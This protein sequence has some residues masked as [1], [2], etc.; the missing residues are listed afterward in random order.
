MLLAKKT[1]YR[2]PDG[3][4]IIRRRHCSRKLYRSW[5]VCGDLLWETFPLAGPAPKTIRIELHDT[6]AKDRVEIINSPQDHVYCDGVEHR[7]FVAGFDWLQPHL[8]KYGIV[9]AE[10]WY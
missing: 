10:V 8:K 5:F 7:L 3:D 6:P 1:M 4:Y 2:G 9:Y